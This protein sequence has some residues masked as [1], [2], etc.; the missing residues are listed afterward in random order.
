MLKEIRKNYRRLIAFLLSA[1]MIIT[2]VGGNAGTVFAAEEREVSLF[3]ADGQNILEAVSG[4]KDQEPFSRE[5]LDEMELDAKQKSAVKK[6]EKLLLPEDGKVYELELEIDS[7]FAVEGTD[8]RVFYCAKTEEVIFLFLNESSQAVDCCVNIDGYETK[9]VTVGANAN[10]ADTAELEEESQNAGESEEES[11]E[12]RE[13]EGAS[14]SGGA[15]SGGSSG[16]SSSGSSSSGGSSEGSLSGGASSGASDEKETVNKTDKEE[17]KAEENQDDQEAADSADEGKVSEE[18]EDKAGSDTLNKEEN[19]A[20]EEDEAVDEDKSVNEDTTADK[21]EN[22]ST[23]DKADAS[24]DKADAS[25]DKADASEDKAD[26]SEDKSDASQDKGSNEGSADKSDSA[27]GASDSKNESSDSGSDSSKDSS[28][29]D[30]ASDTSDKSSSSDEASSSSDKSSGD[31][32]SESSDS[33]SKDSS[34]NDKSSSDNS[35]S[36]SKSDSSDQEKSLSVSYHK[37]AIAAVALDD[38]QDAAETDGEETEAE[39]TAEETEEVI[40]ESVEDSE[41]ETEESEKETE[42]EPETTAEAETVEGTTAAVEENTTAGVETDSKDEN[43]EEELEET[44]AADKTETTEESTAEGE[45]QEGTEAEETTQEETEETLPEDS[46]S[47]EEESKTTT[48]SADAEETTTEVSGENASEEATDNAEEAGDGDVKE[49]DE[50]GDDWEIP[51]KAYDAVTIQQTMTARAYCVKLE[52]VKK[53]VELNLGVELEETQFH[54]EYQMN[55]EDA[56]EV[57]GD[58]YV[59]EGEDLYF[60]VEAKEGFEVAAV[61]ANG[62]Q[63]EAITDFSSHVNEEAW[64]GYANVYRLEAIEEDVQVEV[65]LAELEAIIPAA[66]Y[67]AETADAYF[68]VDVPEGAFKEEVELKAVKI[69]GETELKA[70]TEQANDTLKENQSIASVMA[71]DISFFSLESGKE[72]EPLQAVAVS[73]S[74]KEAMVTSEEAEDVKEIS[75]VHL[76]DSAQAETVATVENVDTTEFTFR[77]ESFSTYLFALIM[78]PKVSVDG[79]TYPSIKIAANKAEDGATITLLD[80]ITESLELTDRSFTFDLNGHTWTGKGNSTLIANISKKNVSIRLTGGTIIAD[81]GYR[82]V[83][84]AKK[85]TAGVYGNLQMTGVTLQG[86]GSTLTKT[87]AVASGTLKKSGG[88]LAAVDTNVVAENCEFRNGIAGDKGGA[89]LVAPYYTGSQVEASFTGCSFHGNRASRG[90]AISSEVSG[91]HTGRAILLKVD[92]CTFEENTASSGGAIVLESDNTGAK[93]SVKA[94]ITNETQFI[95]NEASYYGGAIYSETKGFYEDDALTVAN[96]YFTENTATGSGGGGAIYAKTSLNLSNVEFRENTSQS[97]GGAIYVNNSESTVFNATFDKAKFISNTTTSSGG[98]MAISLT[99][100]KEGTIALQN[101]TIFEGNQSAAK[102]FGN[103]GGGAI[104]A[105]AKMGVKVS[106]S[107]VDIH[108]NS[109][110]GDGGAISADIKNLEATD[111][112]IYNNTAGKAGGG[113]HLKASQKDAQAVFTRTEV[114]GNTAQTAG[115]GINLPGTLETGKAIFNNCTIS[116]NTAGTN[117]GGIYSQLPEITISDTVVNG[118]TAN[119]SYGGGAYLSSYKGGG[120][121]TVSGSTVF[122]GNKAPNDPKTAAFKISGNTPS[123]DVFVR[124]SSGTSSTKSEATLQGFDELLAKE[125]AMGNITYKLAHTNPATQKYG[126]AKNVSSAYSVGY[127]STKAV[128]DCVYLSTS[129]IV[130]EA[131]GS[132]NVVMETTLERAVTSAK[133]ENFN[134]IYVCGTVN[135]TKEDEEILNNS[136]ITFKRC[137]ECTNTVLF[138]I[139]KGE[140]VTFNGIK[141]DGD[142]ILSTAALVSVA[143]TLT[144]DG[145]SDIRNGNNSS[146]SGGGAIYVNADATLNIKGGKIEDNTAVNGGAIATGIVTPVINISGGTIRGNRASKD[147]GAIFSNSAILHINGGL[148]ESNI[149]SSNGGAICAEG[150]QKEFGRHSKVYVEGGT[151]RDN[152]CAGNGGG[153]IYVAFFSELY[154]GEKGGRPLFENNRTSQLGGAIALYQ[155]ATGKIYQGDFIGNKTVAALSNNAGGGALY[156]NAGCSMEMKNLYVVGNTQKKST[157]GGG[158]LYTCSTGRTAIFKTEGAFIAEN[159]GAGGGP[160]DIY[161]WGGNGAVAYVSDYVLGGAAANWTRSN[162]AEAP[163]LW[164]TNQSFIIVSHVVSEGKATAEA[165]ARSEGVVMEGNHSDSWGAAIANNG[166]LVIG[167]EELTLTVNKD[168]KGDE[169]KVPDGILVY[170][171]KQLNGGKWDKVTLGERPDDAYVILNQNNKWSYTWENL[172]DSKAVDWS[173]AEAGINGFTGTISEPE[174]DKKWDKVGKHYII[175]LTNTEDPDKKSARLQVEKQVFASESNPDEEFTFTVYL[176]A[177]GPFAYRVWES[178]HKLSDLMPIYEETSESPYISKFEI[179]LKAGQMF[180]IDGIPVGTL[181]AVKEDTGKYLSYIDG[182]LN[183]DAEI[184]GHIESGDNSI[185]YMNTEK[186]ELKVKKVWDDADDQ[187]G[188]RANVITVELV[189]VVEEL[190]DGELKK[191]DVL[192][193]KTLDLNQENG[194]T[195]TFANLPKFDVDGSKIEWK[196]AEINLDKYQYISKIEREEQTINGKQEVTFIITNSHT[197]ETVNISGEKIWNDINN[198]DGK[199]PESIVVKLFANGEEVSSKTVTAE[200]GWKW[201]FENLPKFYNHGTPIAYTFVETGIG[202]TGYSITEIVHPNQDNAYQG[203]IVNTYSPEKV[204]RSV[205]KKWDDNENQDGKRFESIMVQL[206]ADGS[207]VGDPLVLSEKNNWQDNWKDLPKYKDGKVIIY[208]VIE[209]S[210]LGPYIS[211]VTYE[212]ET[213]LFTVTNKYTPEVK[214]LKATK[215]WEDQNNQANLRPAGVEVQL[216]AD[217]IPEGAAVTLNEGN[218][219]SYEWKDLPVNKNGKE[220]VYTVVENTVIDKYSTTY[221]FN[222]ETNMFTIT[223]T[224][225]PDNPPPT[226]PDNP[227][228]TTP[229]T[230]GN[231]S[232]PPGGGGGN[233]IDPNPPPSR[234]ITPTPPTEI[235]PED[236]PLVTLDPEDVPLAMMPPEDPV[237]LVPIDDDNVP[238]FGLP[239]TG[240]RSVST[241]ALLGMMVFSLMAACGIYVKKNKEDE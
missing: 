184:H 240:D 48:E 36:D 144:I 129:G 221:A 238:L 28:S 38:L 148:L 106:L 44:T 195:A 157:T 186:T 116:D 193:G 96:S 40:E 167:A 151:F 61:Y 208:E 4:V 130:H 60:A 213:R 220:I 72:V 71:Y 43:I 131:S 68:M 199:R 152:S 11:E 81:A 8:L 85:S 107:D 203:K 88:I 147:G 198:Q 125:T 3:M 161:F 142:K 18:N 149:A 42:I 228:P 16:G 128:G 51:G 218:Q 104:H 76:P 215:V 83:E 47:A 97:L 22:S 95:K 121:Y 202:E 86:S 196:V 111:T 227:P 182:V 158:G 82:A 138:H 211:S 56:A 58:A 188:L 92:N 230:P 67:T 160:A 29:S 155:W 31:S 126:Y 217:G 118:N 35:S 87:I 141:I 25:Q 14:S 55:L 33:S 139:E 10:A 223:N 109:A 45:S 224:H 137:S 17:S 237:V 171:M 24:E 26:A 77:A 12:S 46:K 187:D 23:Q 32:N 234:T 102:S 200:D 180:I 70:L 79:E 209:T 201:T 236:V 164:G 2:N 101:G 154:V 166:S 178:N 233:R 216:M 226:T 93:A 183:E 117:G 69:E 176:G 98:A 189:K 174:L 59:A 49:S 94:E 99:K 185:V 181:Y 219:W 212:E 84:M 119:K 9:L 91:K 19:S 168:W 5:D 134:E 122:Y 115:G 190:I 110:K 156:I 235:P 53:A 34:S 75:V 108:D 175:T 30:K 15:S 239:R 214:T 150:I 170:L 66:V 21:E 241:G 194:W 225:T 103:D 112:K 127:Y 100:A 197:P 179:S 143:G 74:F 169:T 78:T 204:N 113:I 192:T 63:L 124:N 20:K 62:S 191:K 114:R 177:S 65:E 6:F 132:G 123:A 39:T 210:E 73:M 120:A 1:A 37:A 7:D 13:N 231:P 52:D 162:G 222:E 90:G 205:V 50:L 41:A 165:I 27:S 80:D 206:L 146:S 54:V 229:D 153:A 57:I 140:D 232:N 163:E 135:I 173:V 133:A 89:V 105:M 207:A 136:G 64:K 159:T 172:G 145:E